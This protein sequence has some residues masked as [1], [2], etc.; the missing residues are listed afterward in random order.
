M[1]S[2]LKLRC[3]V[4]LVGEGACPPEDVGGAPGYAEFLQAIADPE[5]PEHGDMRA[6]IGRPFD[7]NAFDVQE[8]QER[9]NEIKL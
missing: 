5:H 9:L 8:A 3:P 2:E 1:A 7:P 4:C 6:W